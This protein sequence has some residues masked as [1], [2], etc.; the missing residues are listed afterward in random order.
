MPSPGKHRG[1]QE[2]APSSRILV[3]LEGSTADAAILAYVESLARDS[4]A[5]IVLLRVAHY[6]TRDTRAAELA[7]SQAILEEAA[8]QLGKQGVRVRTL[9]G[10]GEVAASISEEARTLGADLI[11]MAAHGHGALRR[12]L[13]GS[14]PDRVRQISEVPVLLVK[15]RR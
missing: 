14:V 5:E 11:A 7:E 8:R 1:T 3:P 12:S 13:E 4:D 10:H 15:A 2:V 9:I 6:H